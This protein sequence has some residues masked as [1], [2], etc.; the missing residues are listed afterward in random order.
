MAPN[1]VTPSQR[2][3]TSFEE[4]WIGD[5]LDY[6]FLLCL[7]SVCLGI[8]QQLAKLTTTQL[9]LLSALDK[10]S[11]AVVDLGVNIDGHSANH[12]RPRRRAT[13]IVPIPTTPASDGQV[14]TDFGGREDA[15]TRVREQPS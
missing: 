2:H 14:F 9:T 10:P 4:G 3:A 8:R 15:G 5:T 12:G 6:F 1:Y 11:S 7:V 13:P